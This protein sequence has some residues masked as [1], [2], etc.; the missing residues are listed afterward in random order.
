M[1]TIQSEQQLENNLIAQLK[2]LDYDFVVLPDED[3]L[4]K[5]LKRQIEIH[6]SKLLKNQELSDSEFERVMNHLSRGN[7]FEKAEI[8]RD[9]MTLEM[10]N[11]EKIYLEFMNTDHWCRNEFQVSNQITIKG[12]YTNRYDV[13][14]LINGI[15]MVQ[16]ELKRR[17]LELKEAF[18]QTNRYDR[19]SYG[20]GAGLFGYIQMFVISNGVNTKYYA[21]NPVKKRDFKQTFFWSDE[22]NVL[23]TN[24]EK[25]TD[26][27]LE[28][29]HVSKMI[30]KYTVL[31]QSD[32]MLMILRP[33]QYYATE[34]IID[35]VKN[36]NKNGY[37]WH[38]TGSGKTLTSF[39]TS[40]ILRKLPWIKKI[41]FVV[42]RKDL[43]YQT[44]KE[45]D[46]F[47]KWSVDA[48]DNTKKLVEQLSGDDTL[49]ITTL[50]KLNN[51][52]FK[53]SYKSQ[54]EHLR[55]EKIVF[56]F[57]EC[58]RSQF[59]DTHNRIKNFFDNAQMF[60]FTGTPILA[61]NHSNKRTT[62]DLF[63]KCLH[64]YV[65]T[66]A[67]K[68]ENVLKFSIEYLN[69]FKTKEE[70]EKEWDL[71]VAG[72]NTKEVFEDPKRLENNVDYILKIHNGKTHSRSFTAMFCVS[73][74]DMLIAYY[75]LF[76]KKDHNLKIATIFS[77]WANEEDKE[78][79]GN[80]DDADII[81]P[82]WQENKHSREKLDE[83]IADYNA[84]FETNYSTKDSKTFYNYYK[85][86]A[87]RVK[88]KE[89]DILIVVN[90]FLTGFD[91]KALNTLYVDKNLRYHGLIQAFSRT[92]RIMW[93]VKSQWNIVCFRNLKKATDEAIA[94]FSNPDAK[95]TIV[96]KPYNEYTRDFNNALKKLSELTPTVESVDDLLWE[97]QKL[98]FIQTF[99]AL[100]RIKNILITFSE[101]NF[102]DLWIDAQTYEDYQAKY[103]DMYDSVKNE[104]ESEMISILE[105]IDFE[106]ELLQTDI[107]NVD[108]ILTL[109]WNLIDAKDQS[110]SEKIETQIK[111]LLNSEVT[112]RSK[113]ELILQFIEENLPKI[114][115]TSDLWKV[116]AQFMD[117]KK[118]EL[119]EKLCSEENINSDEFES[120]MSS[121][122][123]N[124]KVPSEDD[125]FETII[126]KPDFF[127]RP[128]VM[129]RIVEKM[130]DFVKVFES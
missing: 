16:I 116:F 15:P 51:A 23:I 48:T 50:Q 54:I 6:N 53:E 87:K 124:W 52:I 103:L 28:P 77:Y 91:S 14:L 31:N 11:G 80:V 117:S 63:E 107:I 55:D 58:H 126:K 101:F 102:E 59:W 128:T 69:T 111:K 105:D 25:F 12:K 73:N 27:F 76:K 81:V 89:I 130:K 109:L 32:K 67:I 114:Q 49:I 94:L 119:F 30:A 62:A 3:A 92:N 104:K 82:A 70:F 75:E 17:G 78:A 93:Q 66:D 4:I 83:Y 61:K 113:K 37:I 118:S 95:D 74:I 56:I 100:A 123:Y 42:D 24:L 121:F 65:I 45:F 72:I 79:D 21:N 64:K 5:N 41:L 97:E 68:D 106:I 36:S 13:T 43:D 8:L 60:G 115:N 47:E 18:N 88:K 129:K 127:E 35:R 22:E 44:Q 112:L 120:I 1:N 38:T 90:M 57:D 10:D 26:V 2:K 86:I 125:I 110:E 20:A 7:I 98:T 99:R 108:Y 29:C 40:Q 39:K 9:K 33:Y 46:S 71:Q 19:H 85:D 96:I 84:M 34:S 122:I